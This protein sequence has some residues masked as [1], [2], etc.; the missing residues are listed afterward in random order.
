MRRILLIEDDLNTLSGL[1]ELLGEEGYQV[2][3]AAHAQ[4]ARGIMATKN[5]DMVLCDYC[6]PD[7][8]GVDFCSELKKFYPDLRLFLFSA[9]YNNKMIAATRRHE[10]EKIFLKP[11]DLDELL[12]TL[13]TYSTQ[14]KIDKSFHIHLE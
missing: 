3:G 2:F 12:E 4:E 9:F 1:I 10:I 5:I 6:L 13:F 14:I 11:I 7:I 8:N